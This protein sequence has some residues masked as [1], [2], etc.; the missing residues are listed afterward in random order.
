MFIKEFDIS[1]LNNE[2]GFL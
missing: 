1:R 2:R